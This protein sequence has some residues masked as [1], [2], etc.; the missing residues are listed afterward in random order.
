[1]REIWFKFLY[2]LWVIL[3][4]N[5]LS[6]W[7][8]SLH[9]PSIRTKT[10]ITALFYAEMPGSNAINYPLISLLHHLHQ[11][12]PHNIKHLTSPLDSYK[13]LALWVEAEETVFSAREEENNERL[14]QQELQS[15]RIFRHKQRCG[16]QICFPTTLLRGSQRKKNIS[17]KDTAQAWTVK[18]W[19][20][21]KF[22][23]RP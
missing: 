16:S 2:F 15:I 13:L 1:M 10:S 12:Q 14:R 6:T 21:Q 18:M 4:I 17:R 11:P 7:T 9:C 23:R 19:D 22:L 8:L 20:C 3:T 5:I